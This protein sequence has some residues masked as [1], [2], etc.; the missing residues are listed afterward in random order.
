MSKLIEIDRKRDRLTLMYDPLSIRQVCVV[1]L[2]GLGFFVYV[3]VNAVVQDF[4]QST[5]T[6]ADI[7]GGAIFIGGLLFVMGYIYSRLR[8]LQI[9]AIAI[10]DSFK[11]RFSLTHFRG[12]RIF[13]SEACTLQNLR[14]VSL[15]LQLVPREK[16]LRF[17]RRY[18]LVFH[19]PDGRSQL[20]LRE[21][22]LSEREARAV[23]QAI[24]D[25]L[26]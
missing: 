22:L 15:H 20:F 14:H 19:L 16:S 9:C 3:I 11:N 8:E 24:E 18:N 7:L 26:T 25:F 13:L 4:L 21:T 17:K 2:V 6:T 10:L 23:L 5:A 1:M 12:S